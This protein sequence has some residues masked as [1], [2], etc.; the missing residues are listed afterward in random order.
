MNSNKKKTDY[1][2]YMRRCDEVIAKGLPIQ[3][4]L[5]LLLEIAGEY[6]FSQK[7]NSG[8]QPE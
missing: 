2:E 5:V 1:A 6:D 3:D 7:E 8:E 4:T